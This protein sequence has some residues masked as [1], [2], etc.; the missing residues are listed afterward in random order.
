MNRLAC[1]CGFV[2]HLFS[3][4]LVHMVNGMDR[5]MQ[6]ATR[7]EIKICVVVDHPKYKP[8]E[9]R[10]HAGGSG[11]LSYTWRISDPFYSGMNRHVLTKRRASPVLFVSSCYRAPV[12]QR[13]LSS[14]LSFEIM[15]TWFVCFVSSSCI[16]LVLN[17]IPMFAQEST[18][19]KENFVRASIFVYT[20]IHRQTETD[21]HI[22]A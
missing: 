15:C 14:F 16:F 3:I 6:N 20:F 5:C 4:P 9:R 2:S 19:P 7:N 21:T 8:S 10:P 22:H 12:C 13:T 18:R 17:I 1:V 11:S